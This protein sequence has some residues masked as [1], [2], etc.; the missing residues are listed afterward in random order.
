MRAPGEE[1]R[2]RARPTYEVDHLR[3]V[4]VCRILAGPRRQDLGVDRHYVVVTATTRPPR[5]PRASSDPG[6]A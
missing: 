6:T 3:R 1:M 4:L 2:R 5:P